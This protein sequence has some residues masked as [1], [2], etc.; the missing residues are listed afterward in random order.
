[1]TG[2]RCYY[3]FSVA[4]DADY[5]PI[6]IR[7]EQWRHAPWGQTYLDAVSICLSPEEAEDLMKK[8]KQTGAWHRY[9]KEKK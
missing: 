4:D 5:P 7:V 6:Y 9:C 2:R 3:T 8:I 1:M